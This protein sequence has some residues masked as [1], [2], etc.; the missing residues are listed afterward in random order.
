MHVQV[1]TDRNVEGRDALSVRVS[2]T[3]EP[4]LR[5]II[6]S[7]TQVEVHLTS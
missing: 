7:V 5:R 2:G 6:E 4:A 1:N 3:V